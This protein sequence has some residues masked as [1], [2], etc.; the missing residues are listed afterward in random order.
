MYPWS[1]MGRVG[2]KMGLALIEASAN[3]TKLKGGKKR[4]EEERK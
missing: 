3:S 1:I 2:S 4:I